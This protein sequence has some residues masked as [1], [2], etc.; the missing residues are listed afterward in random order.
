LSGEQ[1][2]ALI[3]LHFDEMHRFSPE[4]SCHVMTVDRLRSPDVTFFSAWDGAVLAGCGAIKTLDAAHGELK[5]M[6]AAPAYRGRGVGKAILQRLIAEGRARG[7]TRLSLETGSG[8]RF[9]PAFGLYRAHGFVA[10]APFADYRA[11]PFSRFLSL[12]L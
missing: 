3:A 12:A 7:Y 8:A 2:A 4:N 10:C 9:E 6:R 1:I 11:D 5:S